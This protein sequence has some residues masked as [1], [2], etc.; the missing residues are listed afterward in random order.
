MLVFIGYLL[1]V[2]AFQPLGTASNFFAPKIMKNLGTPLLW[3]VQKYLPL[4]F[5]A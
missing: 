4:A 5:Q 1:S 2:P 3:G